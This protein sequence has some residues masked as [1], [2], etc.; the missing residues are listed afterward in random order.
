[1]GHEG[2]SWLGLSW[3]GLDNNKTYRIDA[4]GTIAEARSASI[5]V[6]A[7]IAE[8]RSGSINA[9]GFIAS[10]R[11]YSIDAGGFIL[12]FA[13]HSITVGGRIAEEKSVSIN[14]GGII[15]SA[16]SGNITAGGRIAA[17]S[18]YSI[19][20]GG[21][22]IGWQD[23]T[24]QVQAMI[25]QLRSSSINVSGRV[26]QFRENTIQAISKIASAP[27][28]YTIDVGGSV[29]GIFAHTINVNGII[30]LPQ[31]HTIQATGYVME[32]PY[33]SINSINI[34]NEML[35]GL[36]SNGPEMKL[37][38]I[39]FPGQRRSVILDGGSSPLSYDFDAYFSNQD[40]AFDYVAGLKSVDGDMRFYPGDS[41]Y[42]HKITYIET[43]R[44]KRYKERYVVRTKVHFENPELYSD[45]EQE[46]TSGSIILPRTS[47]D[48]VNAGHYD[49]PLELLQ[50]TGHYAAG[51]PKYL[52]YS[53]VDGVNQLDTIDLCDQLLSEEQI[54]LDENG[55]L[56]STYAD[57]Y[58]T[59]TKYNQDAT[60]YNAVVS[61][62]KVVVGANG[63]Y[64][65]DFLGPWPLKDS[66]EIL[67]TLHIVQGSPYIE[68]SVDG[69]A[70][71]KTAVTASRIKDNVET[72]YYI[73]AAGYKNIRVRFRCGA[74]DI[75]DVLGVAFTAIRRTRGVATPKIEAGTTRQIRISDGSGSTHSV[76]IYA[77]YRD[78]RHQI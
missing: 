31:H 30:T 66:M 5:N 41:M 35:E 11:N 71:Y 20:A 19:N 58:S 14:T 17:R 28:P 50:I 42:F 67:A 2:L 32:M 44:A 53:I 7:Y 51:R 77:K 55:L 24:I 52:V 21:N 48:I 16:K 47:G 59:S 25:A 46:W 78:M 76:S 43:Q 75:L 6:Q 62:G 54:E 74:Y 1:M 39:T 12:G 40:A 33:Y 65:Y 45:L 9:G 63:Y 23:H 57:D 15:A 60:A 61:G 13:E 10:F 8:S 18:I 26:A 73:P 29:C 72:V 22:I 49:A 64:Y 56:T 70:T 3:L 38:K 34:T 27:D 36:K 4:T 68:Y 37:D 69:G